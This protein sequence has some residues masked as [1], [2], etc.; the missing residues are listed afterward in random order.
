MN[1]KL[2]PYYIEAFEMI[3]MRAKEL[4]FEENCFNEYIFDTI[5]DAVFVINSPIEQILYIAIH[6]Y[7]NKKNISFYVEPQHEINDKEHKYI[8]DFYIS[9]DEYVNNFLKEDFKLIIE[10]DGFNYHSSKNQM[11]YDYERENILKLNGYDV[12]RFTGSQIYNDPMDC[13]KKIMKYIKLKGVD[14]T[15][16]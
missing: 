3:P 13:V 2:I 12:L 6:I 11:T 7:F 15:N 14:R 1:K 10:C 8:A 16:E 9:Y 5:S 4:L